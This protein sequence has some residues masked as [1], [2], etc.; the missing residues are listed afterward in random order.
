MDNMMGHEEIDSLMDVILTI[1]FMTFCA[2]AIGYMV[3]V[4]SGF[5]QHFHGTDKLEVDANSAAEMDPMYFT[6]FQAYMFAY[7]MDAYSD[8][9]LTWLGGSDYPV[10]ARIDGSDNNHVTIC[11]LDENGDVR[12]NFMAWRNQMIT[13]GI[14][15]GHTGRDVKSVIKSVVAMPPNKI[16]T[17]SA[18][19]TINGETKKLR[20]HLELTDKYINNYENVF[21]NVGHKL[22]ER[23]KVYQWVIVPSYR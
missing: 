22:V 12:P 1:L 21:S 17:G 9:P 7:M 4:M 16:Y 18:T 11:A 3:V 2:L 20:F 5:A 23:R 6:G 8:Q 14:A 15:T 10:S 19:R 13:G